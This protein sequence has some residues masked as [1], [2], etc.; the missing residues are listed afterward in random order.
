MKLQINRE[1]LLPPLNLVSSVV[2]KRQTLPI[3]ANIFF[4]LEAGTL[5]LVGTDLEVEITE[6]IP[7]VKGDNMSFTVSSLKMLN[8]CRMFPVDADIQFELKEDS[9]IVK[10]GRSRFTLK[11]LA[12]DDF[13]RIQSG[14][15]EERFKIPQ[16]KL[17]SLIDKTSFSMALHD[18]RFYLNG[19]LLE[20]THNN[21]RAIATDG[22]RL[23]QS[24]TNIDLQTNETRQIIVPRKAVLE[25]NRLLNTEK[26]EMELSLEISKNH[27]K[28]SKQ[29]TTIITKLIDGKFPEFK[30]ILET[31]LPIELS[32]NKTLFIETLSRIAVLTSDR[33]KGVKF[34]LNDN[35]LKVTVNNPEQEEAVEELNVNYQ[36]DTVET[37]Y[38]VTYLIDAAKAISTENI[39]IFMQGSDGV[40]MLK[41]PDEEN[42][43]W[44]V[45][46]MRI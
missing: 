20:L 10:S 1:K 5:Y 24:E 40:V 9:V 6:V 27:L 4:Q 45:M 17:K 18:V 21:L 13:P 38:N 15:W 22:H 16:T 41:Q 32:F 2:E 23:A 7:D 19:I 25:I 30:S 8:I 11:T 36:G 34:N 35:I 28:I 44:L 12:A 42:S 14:N 3:L 46:P 39:H 43:V 29:N 31:I 33:F 26:E 37:G